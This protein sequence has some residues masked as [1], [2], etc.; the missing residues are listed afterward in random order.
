MCNTASVLKVQI[1]V[2]SN[3]VA[4]SSAFSLILL[5]RKK[6]NT[7]SIQEMKLELTGKKLCMRRKPQN[8][9]FY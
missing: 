4:M 2:A 8:T 6:I 7:N 3:V 9:Y 5:A 1:L